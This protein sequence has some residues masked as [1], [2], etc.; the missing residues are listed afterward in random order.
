[1]ATAAAS[2][3]A[4]APTAHHKQKL[5][6]LLPSRAS[7]EPTTH[8]LCIF[9]AYPLLHNTANVHR[10]P[11]ATLQRWQPTPLLAYNHSRRRKSSPAHCSCHF[12]RLKLILSVVRPHKPQMK[13][14]HP[15]PDT[16]L[17][18]ACK[19]AHTR[20]TKLPTPTTLQ[21]T[22]RYD[23]WLAKEANQRTHLSPARLLPEPAA[24]P[25]HQP[26]EPGNWEDRPMLPGAGACQSS[27][28]CNQ[29]ITSSLHHGNPATPLQKPNWPYAL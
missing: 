9:H 15:H 11:S 19:A 10:T 28:L 23:G 29:C 14:P 22:C 27:T 25:P 6:I 24:A 7:Q 8:H 12:K 17:Q 13:H 4:A 21:C 5:C 16:R 3:S 20:R 1:M 18:V 2:A 26:Q